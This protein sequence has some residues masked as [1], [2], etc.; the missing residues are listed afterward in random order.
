VSGG[1]P[2]R[3]VVRAPATIANLGPGFDCLGVAL[4]WH[5]EVSVERD[6]SG[7]LGV[8]AAGQGAEA[9]PRDATNL[10]VRTIRS[11]IGDA[12]GLRVHL[13]NAVPVGR[14]FGSSASAIVAGLVAGRALRGE[15]WSRSELVAAAAAIEGHA[16][17][18][19]PCVFGGATA[20]AGGEVLPLGTPA[21]I[22]I[23]A[24]VAPMALSTEAARRALPAEIPFADASANAARAA[25]LAA[26]LAL[27][28]PAHLMA[29]TEDALH[30]PARFA[31]APDAGRLVA[32]LRAR[33]IAAF[34][35]GAGPSVAALVAL[36][37]GDEAEAAARLFAPD[38][39]EIRR[40]SID[41]SGT[42]VVE[43]GRPLA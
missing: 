39:W 2:D 30:Q 3:V 37:G 18:V 32:A 17:N 8:T 40:V 9:I 15:E 6:A 29:A 43:A 5:N 10:V 11:V 7:A 20:V 38:G 41:A 21:G 25:M 42:A 19:A 33:G 13:T 14:G 26:S 27:A 4:A 12:G 31:L 28:E 23:L 24:C 36:R 22:E 1:G 34:L 35:A 16:D